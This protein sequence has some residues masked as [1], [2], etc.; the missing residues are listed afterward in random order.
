MQRIFYC[1]HRRLPLALVQLLSLDHSEVSDHKLNV[2]MA[3]YTNRPY[4]IGNSPYSTVH[5]EGLT[6]W[7]LEAHFN[8]VT[9]DQVMNGCVTAAS[10]YPNQCWH[11][12]RN[13]INSTLVSLEMFIIFTIKSRLKIADLKWKLHHMSQCVWQSIPSPVFY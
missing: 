5:D 8:R 4:L 13:S 10:K 11:F 6:H 9:M 2:F 7:P 12:G 1:R 3:Q